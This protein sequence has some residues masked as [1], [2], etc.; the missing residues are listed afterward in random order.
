MMEGKWGQRAEI[1]KSWG[2]EAGE[3]LK[4]SSFNTSGAT[5]PSKDT[6]LLPNRC[7]SMV[8]VSGQR[9]SSK[10]SKDY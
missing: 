5:E 10:K 7:Q 1:G 6:Q 2:R 9:V 4:E 3:G 8:S